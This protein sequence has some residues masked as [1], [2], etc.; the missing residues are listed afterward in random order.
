MFSF[1]I[2]T[3]VG[4]ISLGRLKTLQCSRQVNTKVCLLVFISGTDRTDCYKSAARAE[5]FF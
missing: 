3:T 4:I 1:L 2:L 5:A